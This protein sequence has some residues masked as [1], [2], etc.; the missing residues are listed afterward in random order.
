EKIYIDTKYFPDS[1]KIKLLNLISEH[2]NLDEVLDG[3]LIKSDNYHALKSLL[4]KFRERVQLIYIDPPFNT[5]ESGFIYV[6]RFL[7]SS[8]LSMMRD[9]LDLAKYFLTKNGSIYLHL[10]HNANYYGRN[11]M[12]DIFGEDNFQREIVW[13]TS[14]VISG[15]KSQADNWIRQHDTILFYGISSN[16]K[17]RKLW[18]LYKEGTEAKNNLGWLDLI[19]ETKDKLYV[20]RYVK[21]SDEENRITKEFVGNYNVMRIGDI[22]NDILSLIYTQLMTRENWEFDNQKPENLLRRII[23]SSTDPRDFVMDFFAGSGTTVA[24]AHKLDRRWIGIEMGAYF[25]DTMLRRMKTVVFGDLRPFLSRD[26]NWKGGGFFKYYEFEQYEDVLRTVKY[27]DSS[28][29]ENPYE[30]PYN[31]YVFM[32][33]LKMLETLKIDYENDKVK[34][35]LAKLYPNIDIAETLSNLLGKWIKKIAPEYVEFEDG[36]KINTKELDYKLI[37]PLIWW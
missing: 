30:D 29:F 17:F 11:L 16:P 36:E 22:W 1:F 20:E 12:D 23:Q 13:N 37:K 6:D 10:D 2:N 21:D 8:W 15:F 4:P 3:Y 31:Q 19:G 33:D 25:E 27:E 7:D 28:F 26:L 32:R 14:E 34:V 9:R 5:K 24:A 18:R 35:D